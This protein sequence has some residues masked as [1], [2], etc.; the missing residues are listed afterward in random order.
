MTQRLEGV[1]SL[2]EASRIAVTRLLIHGPASR[3]DLARKL[4]LSPAT[5]TRITRLLVEDR[6]V[7]DSVALAE[8]RVGL[9]RP[10]QLMEVNV[11]R[12]HLI[13]I[14][15]SNGQ[16]DLVRT[17]MRATVLSEQINPA[18]F[19][20]RRGRHRPGR[21]GR[22]GGAVHRPLVKA[23]G[24]SLAGPV[25]PVSEMVG[26]SPFLGW[27]QVPL[28][29]RIQERTG[30][31]A[32]VENDVRALTAAEHWFGAAAGLTDFAM[33]TVGIGVGCGLVVGDSL[34]D[35]T[36][37]GGGQ[38]GHLPVTEYGPLCERGHRGCVRS[39]LSSS[40]MLRHAAEGLNTDNVTWERFLEL[41]AE[42][43]AVARRV[44]LDSARALGT[45]VGMVAA[46]TAPSKIL[47]SGES[48]GMVPLILSEVLAH[49]V[50]IEH[51]TMPPVPIEVVPF[52]FTEWARGAAVIALQH[53]LKSAVQK[54]D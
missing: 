23:V 29:R 42:G 38:I 5:L 9:G 15:L 20:R 34:V 54:V 2:S 11:D 51:W 32:V 13:G 39:Y 25:S 47:I 26:M 37:G 24:V 4:G 12:F 40:H 36:G 7:T 53:L 28:V 1:P 41:G 22:D 16:M 44:L 48:A 31:L 46:L 3:A 10:S 17:D 8:P 33:V 45:V 30:L 19:Q 50:T 52:T 27:Q 49:A 6:L 14:K 35:G 18:G 43:N 21:H